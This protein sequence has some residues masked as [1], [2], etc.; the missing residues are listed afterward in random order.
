VEKGQFELNVEK[1]E[2]GSIVE[3]KGSTEKRR[4]KR[5]ERRGKEEGE[6]REQ[7]YDDAQT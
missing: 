4:K 7:K 5:R 6:R 3:L 1:G 2:Y